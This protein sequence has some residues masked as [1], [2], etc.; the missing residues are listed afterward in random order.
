[1]FHLFQTN[2]ASVLSGC[3]KSRSRCCTYM[4]FTRI[5]FKCFQMFHTYVCKCFIWML[6]IFAIIFKCFSDVFVS[7]LDVCFKCFIY[8]LLYVATVAS[9]CFK[10]RLSVAHWMRVRSSRWRGRCLGRRGWRPERRMT[11]IGALPCEPNA[12][13]ALSLR[14][15]ALS[16]R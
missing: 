8:F 3:C 16:G 9:G 13:Y 12:P 4:H 15:Q 11:T 10:S 14:V 7:V 6:L 2:V 5:C 1:M